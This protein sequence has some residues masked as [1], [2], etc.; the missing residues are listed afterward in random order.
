MKLRLSAKDTSFTM[1]QLIGKYLLELELEGQELH[2]V[3]EKA[4]ELNGES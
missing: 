3:L 1:D 4:R 2:L